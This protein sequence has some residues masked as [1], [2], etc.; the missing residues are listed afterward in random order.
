LEERTITGAARRIFVSQPAMSRM[1]DRLQDMFDDELLVRTAKGYEPTS[2]ALAIYARLQQL[3]P[4]LEGLF[5]QREFDSSTVKEIFRIETTDWGATVLIPKM[6]QIL[7]QHAPGI[8]ID[9]LPRTSGFE[10]LEANQVDLV[11]TPSLASLQ[12]S[13]EKEAQ[14]LRVE[15]LCQ[16]HM[17]C[18]VRAGHPLAQRRLTL[19]SFCKAKHVVLTPMLGGGR[20]PPVLEEG[21]RRAGRSADDLDTPVRIPYFASVGP[22]VEGTDL[23]ATMPSQVAR[24]LRTPRIRMLPSPSVFRDFTYNHVW[25]SRNDVNPVHSWLREVMRTVAGTVSGAR[26]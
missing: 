19:H 8:E 20:M 24:R 22:I 14:H 25:H 12:G 18:L 3:L 23:I 4:Q 26:P 21:L 15:P 16:E 5:G 17:V 7:A 2:R 9:I 11:L 1:K 10:Q 13:P 6:A